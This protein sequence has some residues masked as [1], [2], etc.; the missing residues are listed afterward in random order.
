MTKAFAALVFG[1]TLLG[2]GIDAPADGQKQSARAITS[3]T[4]SELQTGVHRL[5]FNAGT[6]NTG[7]AIWVPLLV[8]KGAEVG[9]K[10]LL[11]SAVHGDELNGISVIHGLLQSLDVSALRGTLIV[12]PGVNQPGMNANN[13]HFVGSN[14]GGN[15]ADL[16]R[17]F[18]GRLD[19]GNAAERYVGQLW[20]NVFKNN[21][22]FAVD[23]HTQTRGSDYPLFVFADFRNP[24]S[25]KMA[26]DLSPDLIK[27][28]R[29]Q[30]GTLETA[31]MRA[32]IPS[33]TLEVGGPKRWQPELVARSVTGLQNLMKGFEMLPGSKVE[34]AVEPVVGATS[35][36]IYTDVGGFAYIHVGLKERVSKGQKVATMVDAYGGELASYYSPHDGVVLSVATDPLREPGAMLVRI[37][38]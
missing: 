37:L 8:V 5:K 23:L 25:R 9:P 22:D 33:V 12:V 29:G 35:V 26:F 34:P 16:N 28:D 7:E 27:N 36:N 21:A 14:E 31:L 15:M 20:H 32:G 3:L 30:D 4:A 13:R 6:T 17:L 2:A 19:G 18:P 24:T 1:L 11:T 10:L 38:H